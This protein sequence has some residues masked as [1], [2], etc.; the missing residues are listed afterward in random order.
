MRQDTVKT[1]RFN[2]ASPRPRGPWGIWV[3]LAIAM[4]LASASR[5]LE[6]Q[7][8]RS[9]LVETAPIVRDSVRESIETP[10]VTRGRRASIVAAQ[11]GGL[12][13]QRPVEPGDS[14]KKGQRLIVLD[15]ALLDASLTAAGGR[16]T[17][18][19]A[20]LDLAAQEKA[21][22]EELWQNKA[23]AHRELEAA[24]TELI[25][26]KAQVTQIEADIEQLEVQRA[27][28]KVRAPFAGRITEF[29][30]EV[31]EYLPPGGPVARVEE[32]G[33]MEVWTDA[34]EAW[35]ANLF[36]G[37][38]VRIRLDAFPGLTFQGRVEAIIPRADDR[39]HSFPVRIRLDTGKETVPAGM[40]ARVRF[41]F[42]GEGDTLLA[43]RDAIVTDRGERFLYVVRDG[44]ATRVTV[45]PGRSQGSQIE[46]QGDLEAGEL[47]VVKGNER[48]RPG[49]PV[50]TAEPQ[51]PPI[52]TEAARS[53]TSRH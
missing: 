9:A 42:T 5:P 12:V 28:S 44:K 30:T 14:V 2:R 38:E 25:A 46:I 35:Y 39:A 11:V 18:A 6:A 7:P 52:I 23:I 3:Y 49:T 33:M 19:R 24:A 53:P 43:P 41:Q 21:R 31:G 10:G 34:P 37:Q 32:L 48:L 36:K 15:T 22:S 20:R 8:P 1:G 17:E 51:G 50:R 47:V 16:L 26:Q 13:V 40:V 29:N 27:R 45:V 4:A